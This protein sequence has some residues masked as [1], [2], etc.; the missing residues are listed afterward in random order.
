MRVLLILLVFAHFSFE[1]HAQRKEDLMSSKPQYGFIENKGQVKDQN[2]NPRADVKFILALP[3]NNVV[4]TAKGFSY[5]TYVTEEKIRPKSDQALTR[6]GL[7]DSLERD[8]TFK[9]H[10]VDVEFVGANANPEI[11]TEEPSNDYINYYVEGAGVRVQ[12]YG[13]VRYKNIY[14]GVDVEFIAR[15]GKSKPIEYNF[16]VQPSADL[17][18]L[19]LKYK[20]AHINRLVNGRL[21]LSLEH[22]ILTES[23]PASYGEQSKKPS[24]VLFKE[25]KK[26]NKR[27]ASSITNEI[28]VGFDGSVQGLEEALVIDPT[29]SI[30]WGTYFG[31]NLRDEARRLDIDVLG[32]IIFTGYSQSPSGIATSGAFQISRKGN[33]DAFIAKFNANGILKWGTY[34]GGD[35]DEGG[36]DVDTDQNSNIYVGGITGSTNGIS[37]P[38][39]HQ[40]IHGGGFVFGGNPASDG[41]ILKLTPNGNLVWSTYYGGFGSDQLLSIK[42]DGLGNLYVAGNDSSPSALFL[43]KFDLEGTRKWNINYGIEDG[44]RDNAEVWYIQC[45]SNGGVYISGRTGSKIGFSTPSAHQS[46]PLSS[47]GWEGFFAKFTTDG[48]REWVT[49]YPTSHIVNLTI[50]SVDEIYITGLTQSQTGI[51]TPGAFQNSLNGIQDA[52][53]AKFNT[54]GVRQWGTYYGG[55]LSE[56]GLSLVSTDSE[57]FLVGVTNSRTGIATP[58]AYKCIMAISDPQDTYIAKFDTN[59]NRKWGTYFGNDLFDVPYD[60]EL[61]G[62]FLYIT[63]YAFD[64]RGAAEFITTPGSFK[65]SQSDL[66]FY[67]DAFVTKLNI[68][69]ES[70]VPPDFASLSI[71]NSF[72]LCAT[73]F[74]ILGLNDCQTSFA[75]NFGDGTT[76]TERNPI[77]VYNSSGTYNASVKLTYNPCN[78]VIL[79]KQITFSPTTAAIENKLI[80]AES[81]IKNQIITASAST[82]SDSWPLPHDNAA[83]R[84][85]SGFVNGTEGVWRSDASYVFDTVRQHSV[86]T[87]LRQDGTYSLLH[88]DWGT[89]QYDIVPNWI[90]ANSM[91]EYS[92][93]SYELENRDVLGIYSAALYDYG[94]HLPSANGVNM[95]NG[96]M[97]FTS[98]EVSD[99]KPTGNW[100]ISNL[101]TPASLAYHVPVGLGHLAVIEATLAELELVNRV[102]VSAQRNFFLGSLIN[103]QSKPTTFLQ[104]VNILCKQ[105]HPTNPNLTIVVLDKSPFE[106]IWRGKITVNLTAL[107]AVAADLDNVVAHS[108]KKSLKITA[109]KTFRQ[110]LLRLEPGKPYWVNAWVSVNNPH[111]LTPVLASNLGIDITLKDKQGVSVGTFSFQPAGQVIE[112][113][114]QVKGSFVSPIK[115]PLV[116]IK[117]KPGSIGTAWYDDLRLQPERGN[118][119]AY[120]YDLQD[121]R[122]R[123]ILDEENFASFFFYD[124]EGNLYLTKKETERGIKTITENMS[125]QVERE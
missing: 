109:D 17:N 72:F 9:Y 96:E 80:E 21:E 117:F 77:H 102:D 29:P 110:E 57:L 54:N 85:R 118:M 123:A 81:D 31:G 35:F 101:A 44:E 93:Y 62:N 75:W 100:M 18:L 25:I 12:H 2:N 14:P 97:A 99:G 53:I 34:F 1:A 91:T 88:F 16:I 3:N 40:P 104:G 114:Q 15:P 76:S 59:G 60:I 86:P 107:P 20:G 43:A 27:S 47:S 79:T 52:F 38:G 69:V 122:L 4:L 28:I 67:S 58:D 120:V 106:Q 42:L 71:A 64:S 103:R 23:I 84:D 46:V 50:N 98:F 105:V 65:S 87:N 10:R 11:I 73:K 78:D 6:V 113:W 90:K 33:Q 124:A 55:E 30:V 70:C 45:D 111:V 112:G 8:V 36:W 63:G 26:S 92:P 48:Q 121:Y 119:K 56:A 5:D 24:K 22:G 19:Q 125:Y 51:A 37:T 68:S 95:R 115:N 61:D 66:D 108:G 13:V 49:Y 82:F 116:E 39:S 83:L 89:A 94:G 41:F 7:S 32:D 74:S